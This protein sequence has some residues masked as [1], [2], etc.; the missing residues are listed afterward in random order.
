[1]L[2]LPRAIVFAALVVSAS[3]LAHAALIPRYD[4][5]VLDATNGIF[6]R[7]DRRTGTGTIGTMAERPAWL[8]VTS[9]TPIAS[10]AVFQRGDFSSFVDDVVNGWP[11]MAISYL[12]GGGFAFV[13]WLR[14]RA[15]DA[16]QRWKAE[17]LRLDPP[18]MTRI[19]TWARWSILRGGRIQ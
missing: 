9:S 14:N 15:A 8:E 6:L 7:V 19:P 1:M 18:E 4:V 10:P 5:Q 16:E 2:T 13:F 11:F 3:V 12:V 17:H